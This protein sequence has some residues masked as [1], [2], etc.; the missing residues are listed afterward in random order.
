M[1]FPYLR[2]YDRRYRNTFVAMK[3]GDNLVP[4]Y[5]EDVRGSDANPKFL[6]RKVHDSGNMDVDLKDISF[7]DENLI[8]NVPKLG[9]TS[10][11]GSLAFIA[12]KPI[13][14]WKQG[15]SKQNLEIRHYV[16]AMDRDLNMY[17]IFNPHNVELN[18]ALRLVKD[19]KR[20]VRLNRYAGIV[21]TGSD[22]STLVYRSSVLGTNDNGVLHLDSSYRTLVDSIKRMGFNAIELVE[23]LTPEDIIRKY[24]SDQYGIPTNAPY[25]NKAFRTGNKIKS[26]MSVLTC[27]LDTLRMLDR[28]SAA[29]AAMLM[30]YFVHYCNEAYDGAFYSMKRLGNSYVVKFRDED[31]DDFIIPQQSVVNIHNALYMNPNVYKKRGDAW[32]Y[33]QSVRGWFSVDMIDDFHDFLQGFTDTLED[34][35]YMQA[36][37][38]EQGVGDPLQAPRR[39]EIRQ[40][41]LRIRFP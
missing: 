3:E 40:A 14:R 30:N 26:A 29:R 2:D 12:R 13:Q 11:E 7:L 18:D 36:I 34:M 37:L 1:R 20:G 32:A 22:K 6:G 4:Y 16:R 10:S 17:D 23:R 25:I 8:L 27:G 35:G 38:N 15:L 31:T 41:A 39:E 33:L 28:Q 21:G 24:I 9:M 5:V 19:S